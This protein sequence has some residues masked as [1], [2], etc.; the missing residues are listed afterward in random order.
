M[1]G[2]F[3][4]FVFLDVSVIRTDSLRESICF[5]QTMIRSIFLV[6]DRTYVLQNSGIASLW[7]VVWN[8]F[9]LTF[10]TFLEQQ[11]CLRGSMPQQMDFI[12][13]H[14]YVALGLM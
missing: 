8:S 11:M 10:W 12:F 13:M 4:Y 7:L 2:I 6:L 9:L 14:I 3:T 1:F 5:I